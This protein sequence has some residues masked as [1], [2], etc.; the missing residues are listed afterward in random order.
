MGLYSV[1]LIK[2]EILFSAIKDILLR[3]NLVIPNIR[4]QCYDDA[5]VMAGYKSGVA[6]RLLQEQP[7]PCIVT[8]IDMLLNLASGD[9][10]KHITVL[11][12]VLGT[13]FEI[14]KH[15][16]YSPQ[17]EACF[18]RTKLLVQCVTCRSDSLS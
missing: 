7:K 10:I 8:A 15:I 5:P 11:K 16:K 6:T 13:A 18:G 3:F 4:G 2:A 1:D 9:T 14:V 12:D 17:K